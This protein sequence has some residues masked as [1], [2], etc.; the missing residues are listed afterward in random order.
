VVHV[1]G[2]G[3]GAATKV[4]VNGLLHAFNAALAESLVAAEAAG[5]APTRLFDVLAVSVLSNRFVDYKRAAYVDPGSAAVAFDLQTAA[6]DLRLAADASAAAGIRRGPV[7]DA[8]RT[9]ETACAEGYRERDIS[10]LAEWFRSQSHGA[11][12]GDVDHSEQDDRKST[13]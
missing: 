7:A 3:A 5:V 6:K 11:Q 9:H 13:T 2:T 12:P 8:L 10:A 4:A 1:G